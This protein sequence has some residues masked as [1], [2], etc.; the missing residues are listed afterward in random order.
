MEVLISYS[1][2]ISLYHILEYLRSTGVLIIVGRSWADR[3]QAGILCLQIAVVALFL[4][5]AIA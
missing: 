2:Y 5:I 3:H 4:C 1:E